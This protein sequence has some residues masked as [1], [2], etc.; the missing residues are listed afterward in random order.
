[1]T[2]QKSSSATTKAVIAQLHSV[3]LQRDL[4]YEELAEQVGLSSRNLF[5]LMNERGAAMHDRTLHKIRQYLEQAPQEPQ[6]AQQ[7]GS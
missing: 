5:R 1:M 7:A 4:T 2:T 6:S 3:R